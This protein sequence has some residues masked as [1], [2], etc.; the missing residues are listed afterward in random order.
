[1]PRVV[2]IS[3]PSRLH[4]GLYAFG[5]AGRQYGGVGA[6]IAEPRLRLEITEADEFRVVGP[7]AERAAEF[8]RRWAKFQLQPLRCAIQIIETP[9]EHTGLGVGT[10]LGLSI[11]AGLNAFHGLPAAGPLELAMSVG[12]GLRSA[13]GTYGFLQ[14]GL[15]AERG[16]LPH[17]PLSPLDL[18]VDLPST[19]RFA[20]FQPPAAPGLAG[21]EEE[22]AI[23]SLPP[24]P[25]HVTNKL[26]AI[27]QDELFPAAAQGDFAAFSDSLYRYG[28]LA[29]QCFAPRQGGPFNGP[30][31]TR[32]VQTLRDLG[33][34][35]AGQSSWG[36]TIFAICPDEPSATDC[37][38]RFQHVWRES[39]VVCR[40]TPP[41]NSGAEI[42]VS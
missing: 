29:G 15:I 36:P 32:L 30:L 4:F 2:T 3:A 25:Q 40:I 24:V 39:T 9:P 27:A 14:G 28:T 26:I 18:R 37:I 1:M 22:Q 35:G 42:Q 8:T 16:K 38:Q 31:L 11:A 41:T 23:A 34:V 12:R 7:L 19:W 10:Q 6:M 21:G 20:L 33:L 5:G 17:E 13:V